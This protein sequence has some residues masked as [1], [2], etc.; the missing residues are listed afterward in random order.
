MSE[1]TRADAEIDEVLG[2]SF[3]RL[4]ELARLEPDWDSYGG[5]PPSELAITRAADLMR[6]VAQRHWSSLGEAAIPS[7]VAPI[8]DGGIHLEWAG[9]SGDLE[10]QV[11]QQGNLDYLWIDRSGDDR[12][13]QEK[14]GV[15]RG[16]V[17]D[18]IRQVLG[19]PRTTPT[20]C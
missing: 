19:A 14:H 20:A 9:P 16:A 8:A 12:R 15:T 13:F 2:S 6:E 11:G 1:A 17:L 7:F 5:E 3:E 4:D 10:L 18:V